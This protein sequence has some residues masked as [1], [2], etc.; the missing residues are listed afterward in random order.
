MIKLY[1]R[2]CQI[3]NICT[4]FE[5]KTQKWPPTEETKY[6]VYGNAVTGSVGGA[7]QAVTI[8][9]YF[10]EYVLFFSVTGCVEGL[11]PEGQTGTGPGVRQV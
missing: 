1:K 10:N 11:Y 6:I 5:I 2:N 8:S 9:L 3:K 4:Y 7:S